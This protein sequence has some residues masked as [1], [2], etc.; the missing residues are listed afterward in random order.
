[1]E[2]EVGEDIGDTDSGQREASRVAWIGDR[3]DVMHVDRDV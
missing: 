1:M 3:C 2:R